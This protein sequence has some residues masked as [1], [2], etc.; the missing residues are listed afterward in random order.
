MVSGRVGSD[1]IGAWLRDPSQ[2]CPPSRPDGCGQPVMEANHMSKRIARVEPAVTA[3]EVG[4][5]THKHVHEVAVDDRPP[6]ASAPDLGPAACRRIGAA[7]PSW[8][9]GRA[10]S[11]LSRPLGSRA[12]GRTVSGKYVASFVRRHAVRVVG[13][14]QSLRSTR[15]KPCGTTGRVTR[16]TRLMA[17]RSVLAGIAAAVPK[18]ADGRGRRWSAR[19]RSLAIPLSGLHGRFCDHHCSRR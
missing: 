18:S 14:S 12:P 2:S 11:A 13:W 6:I 9:P 5:D 15:R 3:I 7:T 4:A 17:A 19:S 1:R 8:W 16:S 10:R